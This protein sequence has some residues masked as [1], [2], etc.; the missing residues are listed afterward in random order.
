V[1]TTALVAAVTAAACSRPVQTARTTLIAPPSQAEIDAGLAVDYRS[2]S[3]NLGWLFP[4]LGQLCL[5]KKPE[6]AVLSSLAAAEIGT[7]VAVGV[8]TD[9]DADGDG[10][11]DPFQHPGVNLP[12]SAVQD[13]WL[14]GLAH[15]WIT[16]ALARRELYAP[17][18]T[19]A[20]LVAAP[21]NLEVLKRPAVW[22]GVL[23]T[24]A[25]G[26]GVTLALSEDVDTDEVGDDPNLFGETVD[27]TYGYP[28]GGLAGAGLFLHVAPAEEAL[29]RG[30]I[31][32]NLARSMG[33]TQGWVV[34]SLLFG[35]A[36]VPNI[37]ALPEEDRKDY[38]L[39]G[40]PVITAAGFYL[41]WVYRSSDYS[42]APSTAVHFWYD[43]LLTATEFAL[44]PQHSI[45]AP[46][47]M[48]TW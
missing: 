9:Y 15:A 31:Q 18:D 5:G 48:F 3:P 26:I 37:Y 41:G 7:A 16:G 1:R 36:H 22:A 10:Q 28:L 2:C 38:L 14:L 23:G 46:S 42:L 11:P 12:A 29:F 35:L 40:I 19:M 13:L 45:F 21:F 34:A 43:F 27:G 4:G 25:V 8:T 33:Q 24:L 39:Y 44:D 6:A 20:D 17:P 47:M 32:S 30:V